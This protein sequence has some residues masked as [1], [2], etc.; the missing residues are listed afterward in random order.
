MK[1][2]RPVKKGLSLILA[3][4]LLVNMMPLG[5]FDVGITA[6]AGQ[7]GIEEEIL[8]DEETDVPVLQTQAAAS[9]QTD[10]GIA[11]EGME[12]VTEPSG[13]GPNEEELR[14]L[15]QNNTRAEAELSADTETAQECRLNVKWIVEATDGASVQLALA[16][17][18]EVYESC[19]SAGMIQADG[20][21]RG[22][23]SEG[24]EITLQQLEGL[25]DGSRLFV[26]E[27][28]GDGVC[29]FSLEM[30]A[31]QSAEVSRITAKWKFVEATTW[32]DAAYT[33]IKW[34]HAEETLPSETA[35]EYSTEAQTEATTG[36]EG[37]TEA[38]TEATT[39]SEAATEAVTEATTGSEA[40]TEAVTESAVNS[41][42]VANSEI[43]TEDLTEV[44]TESAV[45]PEKETESITEPETLTEV[46]TEPVTE[47]ET[48]AEPETMTETQTEMASEPETTT[49]AQ[50][51]MAA[52]PETLTESDTDTEITTELITEEMT[53]PETVTESGTEL[54]TAT[55]G[56][57]ET[58]TE[59][60]T[61]TQSEITTEQESE[62][63][64]ATEA[65]TE[66]GAEI[67]NVDD[68]EYSASV[69]VE[70]EGTVVRSGKARSRVRRAAARA[71]SGPVDL[72]NYITGAKFNKTEIEAGENVKV[73]IDYRIYASVLENQGTNVLTYQ[74]PSGINPNAEY[75]GVVYDNKGKAVGVYNI[76]RGGKITITLD[77]EFFAN[78]TNVIGNISFWAQLNSSG[79]SED[80]KYT[81]SEDNDMTAT[82]KIKQKQT[83]SGSE[84]EK[85]T[86]LT[87]E[88]EA[89]Y[90]NDT[91]TAKY[92]ITLSSQNGTAGDI[93]RFNDSQELSAGITAGTPMDLKLIKKAADGTTQEL[94]VSDYFDTSEWSNNNKTIIRLKD[95]KALPALAPGESYEVDYSL[96][97]EGIDELN[98]WYNLQNTISAGNNKDNGWD[99]TNLSFNHTWISK[100]GFYDKQTGEILW[101]ITV[102]D[103]GGDL[104]GYKL[105]DE[106]KKNGVLIDDVKSATMVEYDGSEKVA[107][108]EITLPYTFERGK[109][110]DTTNK[111]VITYKTK[112]SDEFHSS[113]SN[114]A[115]LSK[116]DSKFETGEIGQNITKNDG[117]L[118]K[119]YTEPGKDETEEAGVYR[120]QV[121]ITAPSDGIKSD[122]YYLDEMSRE[123]WQN[124]D[125][126]KGS[127][128]YMTAAQLKALEVLVKE[129]DSA[130]TEYPKLD[131]QYYTIQVEINGQWVNF[132]DQSGPFRKYRI[133]F[134]GDEATGRLPEN[135]EQLILKY[136]TTGDLSDMENGATWTF[137]NKGTFY[138]DG[139]SASD[140]DSK[141][142]SKGGYLKK[143]DIGG[144]NGSYVYDDTKGILYYCLVINELGSL[145]KTGGGD[146]TITDQLPAGT[147]LY[148]TPYNISTTSRGK[149]NPGNP[150]NDCK[151]KMYVY[152][153]N[154]LTDKPAAQN[155]PKDDGTYG[156]V[157][158]V[159][160]QSY[161]ASSIKYD[162]TTNI[163]QV[164]IPEF[165]YSF[166]ANSSDLDQRY[167][168]Y[169]FY[170][171][172]IKDETLKTMQD[173]QTF[174][175][176]AKLSWKGG[177]AGDE[178]TSTVKK[179]YISK[180]HNP[181]ANDAENEIS[182]RVVI[183]PGGETKANGNPFTVT[184]SVDYSKHTADGKSYILG[185][186]LKPQSLHL[187]Y[188]R[189]DGTKGA[190]LDAS[191]YSLK[192]TET[193][194]R[195]EMVLTV[196]D[197]TPLIL[198]YTY[199]ISI[200]VDLLSGLNWTEYTFTNNI[201]MAGGYNESSS[202]TDKDKVQGS[203]ATVKVDRIELAK[204]DKDNENIYL[205][206]AKFKLQ[207]YIGTP[208]QENWADDAN[209]EDVKLYTTGASG[210]VVLGGLVDN[211]A[212]RLIETEAPTNYV[213]DSTPHYF[214]L[215]S[216]QTDS[217]AA[218][219]NGF[220]EIAMNSA[221]GYITLA[222][223]KGETKNTSIEVRKNW[224]SSQGVTLEPDKVLDAQG[225]KVLS[226]KLSL[227]RKQEEN[228]EI[229]DSD[230]PLEEVEMAANDMGEWYHIFNHL[231]AEDENGNPYYYYVKEGAM[232]VLNA[233]NEEVTIPVS[234]AYVGSSD[235]DKGITGG[236][237]TLSNQKKPGTTSV[238]V[239]KKWKSGTPQTEVPVTLYRFKTPYKA[240]ET[241][242]TKEITCTLEY[243]VRNPNNY[244][245][246]KYGTKT[247]SR[248]VKI[249]LSGSN[250][251]LKVQDYR[252]PQSAQYTENGK[253]AALTVHDVGSGYHAFILR[254]VKSDIVL[255]LVYADNSEVTLNA[256]EAETILTDGASNMPVLPEDAEEIQTVTLGAAQNSDRATTGWTWNW[257]DLDD[258]YYYYVVEGDAEKGY[259][260][261]Y[262]AYYLYTY[263]DEA[264]ASLEKV[265]ITNE[266]TRDEN[267]T[268]I[269]VKKVWVDEKGA[270]LSSDAHPDSITVE[271]WKRDAYN[272]EA[273][274]ST[275]TLGSQNA[276]KSGYSED[277]W[278]YTWSKIP[279]GN[280]YAKETDTLSMY[281]VTYSGNGEE[282]K[283]SAKEASI[284]DGTITIT[285]QKSVSVIKVSK[286]WVHADGETPLKDGEHPNS[287]Q[288]QLYKEQLEN[289]SLVYRA[290]GDPVTLGFEQKSE[291][292]YSDDG[293]TYTWPEM[294][295]GNYY[296]EEV[297][298]LSG[299]TV[300]YSVGENGET[301]TSASAATAV[302]GTITIT[303]RKES[304]SLG[305]S[306]RWDDNE[307]SLGIRPDKVKLKLYRTT[308][309]LETEVGNSVT[310]SV[311]W[312]VYGTPNT[313]DP[314]IVISVD[315][316]SRT[317]DWQ[318][319]QFLR[320][321]RLDKNNNWTYTA[322]GLDGSVNGVKYYMTSLTTTGNTGDVKTWF[323]VNEA[324]TGGTLKITAQ[325]HYAVSTT[326]ALN[327][328]ASLIPETTSM[329][330]TT[331]TQA[332]FTVTLPKADG[333]SYTVENAEY[334]EEKELN[335][336]NGWSA[337]WNNLDKMDKDG[338][339]YYYFVVEDSVSGG[340]S[341][342]YE[343]TYKGDGRPIREVDN[344]VV[345]NHLDTSKPISIAVEKKWDDNITDHANYK[346]EVTLYDASGNKVT[347]DKDG[348]Q[349]SN[350]IILNSTNDWKN[351]WINLNPGVYYVRETSAKADDKELTGYTTTYQLGGTELTL[352]DSLRDEAKGAV[353]TTGGTVTITN[354][355]KETGIILPGTGSKYPLVFYG[356]GIAFLSV[357]AVWMFLTLKK[358]NKPY[359][360]GKGG[361]GSDGT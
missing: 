129:K 304:T 226:I 64:T 302:D 345:T 110:K 5:A 184:D 141:K 237:I 194:Q 195:Y 13:L 109:V 268:D 31:P 84:T 169:L 213:L 335:A 21:W 47:A 259:L 273:K 305:V 52:E 126:T 123:P 26:Y 271:L 241:E 97:Y 315:L 40:A 229:S 264:K 146:L 296:V 258:T 301:Q 185:V 233:E 38:V 207:K 247:I 85:K 59:L 332:A 79:D 71:A 280:Y 55:E 137:K 175:N 248:K 313:I 324:G 221:T 89:Q 54:E 153:W 283:T 196:P 171:V 224:I 8:L 181:E 149:Y 151:V 331:S 20:K 88:K 158:G 211:V 298:T 289:S 28:K 24:K 220:T 284:A 18:E 357:S 17:P 134:Q 130:A 102:N 3:V 183:N 131:G 216:T 262:H 135:V 49:E 91:K 173:G 311:D 106:L 41:E 105:N 300:T 334:V 139:G 167:P 246:V 2:L 234:D 261:E 58:E 321:I 61:E 174:T 204:V 60:L 205:K 281:E 186:G 111:F 244:N 253:T 306:K 125:N 225:R 217:T 10:A 6:Q 351:S 128:H 231:P 361:K 188:R 299:Y 176:Q 316:W 12:E 297:G 235:T 228:A 314:N 147:E 348:T 222:N 154:G 214:Y 279:K 164:T 122:S 118:T 193:E 192:C 286:K 215:K 293:W 121:T 77:N 250:L 90:N 72:T 187:Y 209:W 267:E 317:S 74:I 163:L 287:I 144:T 265:Q 45:T 360:A 270:P 7:S 290:Y 295:K 117:T 35:P 309:Q 25:L 326:S 263:R 200:D 347:S 243:E 138:Q 252:I 116:G 127:P 358:K 189:D 210:T 78:A 132:T 256:F 148:E 353:K 319:H 168:I 83:E 227:Y 1:K 274:Y 201:N 282:R 145:P 320:T 325:Q 103:A 350:P 29:S 197:G 329:V 50:T 73:S 236:T 312:T 34:K 100:Q 172:K 323:S 328:A 275:V 22:E 70:T 191:T 179:S 152:Q 14:S 104:D 310:V 33:D 343:I 242:E 180:M 140:E 340:Y 349:I 44:T 339:L 30:Y 199:A 66:T 155:W 162:K 178:T 99:Q 198:E 63:E 208:A 245:E 56:T 177:E 93:T 107:E 42:T 120:W 157:G 27:Q 108:Y 276:G 346:V 67:P 69:S 37:A 156:Y 285:N 98:S 159:D 76:T 355:R 9:R 278:S 101:T 232:T 322:T 333:T 239:E 43:T 16:L 62:S 39:G 203:S 150:V 356:L 260:D 212:Y 330:R 170:A 68:D 218:L 114:K 255:H 112:T 53:E 142:E 307:N 115:D 251:K 81:F 36:S 86:D 82:I 292:G 257:T 96:K 269:T 48:A 249:P 277:G 143:L 15:L 342:T 51:E 65:E 318:N 133:L 354:T 336:S 165:L 160:L 32:S 4:V 19:V 303:N 352:D 337:A 266:T 23:T 119:R 359:Y 57:T 291:E 344:I 294:E 338:N 94:S 75:N 341:P 80:H 272:N 124:S 230:T 136:K 92:K 240:V 87:A 182:Y 95:G 238:L 223:T 327:I 113:Y 190:E 308:E 166:S 202:V 219:P 161:I 206:G 288:V 11:I 46:V 254:K